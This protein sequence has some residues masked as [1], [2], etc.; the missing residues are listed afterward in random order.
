M[1]LLRS[2]VGRAFRPDADR[3]KVFGIEL[4]ALDYVLETAVAQDELCGGLTL[5]NVI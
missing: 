2:V 1:L 3:I 4:H 5:D